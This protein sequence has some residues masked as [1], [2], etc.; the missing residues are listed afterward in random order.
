MK[1]TRYFFVPDAENQTEL[2]QE[3]AAH[4]V[5][6]LRLAGGDEMYLMD[7]AGNFFRAEVAVAAAHRCTYRIMEKLPQQKAW[8]G[9]IH[10]AI[11]PTKMMER[12]E[13]MVEK[14]TEVGFDEVT[15]LNC[16][17]SE[18]KVLRVPRLE[19][20]VVS[21]VKQSRKPWKP[22]VNGLISFSEFVSQPR[23]GRK[24][25]AHCYGEMPRKDLYT[26]LQQ[27]VVDD[28]VTVMVGPEGDFSVDEVQKAMACGYEPVTLGDARLRTETAGL[29]A[30][31]MSQLAKRQ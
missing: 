27:M 20:I 18:R 10:V 17:F 22:L 5:K 11:A 30:V 23:P 4:A 26:E 13:W 9:R 14:A 31:V 25:I 16:K 15:F 21:A 2:P 29:M 28:E 7:G 24:F 3:E 12:M 8:K 1:E 6:V 19:K